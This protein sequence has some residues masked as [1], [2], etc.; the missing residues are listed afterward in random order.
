MS[1]RQKE[2]GK[3][4]K[5]IDIDAPDA[6]QKYVEQ[7][8][9][10]TYIASIYQPKAAFDLS[11]TAQHQKPTKKDVIT[12]NKRLKWQI[13]H[14]NRELTYISLNVSTAKLFVFVDGSF[15]NNKDYNSQIRY[16][17]ILANETTK[18]DEFTINGNLIH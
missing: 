7:R 10:G 17:I 14:L 5:L 4:I 12:L 8:A 15:A 16:E 18:N 3:K 9:R 11:V 13:E 1:L 6:R 2:Q